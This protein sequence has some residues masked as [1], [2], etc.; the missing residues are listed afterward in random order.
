[1]PTMAKHRLTTEDIRYLHRN[2]NEHM[3]NDTGY[4]QFVSISR[5][6]FTE[7]IGCCLVLDVY[8]VWCL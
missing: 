7:Y 1:M 6:Y 2:A 5:S 4:I 3:P 8:L